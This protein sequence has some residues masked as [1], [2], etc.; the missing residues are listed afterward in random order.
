[1][2]VSLN[3]LSSDKTPGH[4]D[5][6]QL[7]VASYSKG[8][9]LFSTCFISLSHRRG[10]SWTCKNELNMCFVFTL[11]RYVIYRLSFVWSVNSKFVL[12][13][14]GSKSGHKVGD[15]MVWLEVG[16]SSLQKTVCVDCRL[17]LLEG[18][19]Q[20]HFYAIFLSQTSWSGKGVKC[21][22]TLLLW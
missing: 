10:L 8:L 2:T 14:K 21:L 22:L 19:W 1:M 7:S 17:S 13:W 12:R 9:K 15:V 16:I 4:F 18:N 20:C 3:L 5:H 6:L 11:H